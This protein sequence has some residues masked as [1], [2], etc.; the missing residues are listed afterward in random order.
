[1]PD[2]S[3]PIAPQ[4]PLGHHKTSQERAQGR[5][6]S[7]PALFGGI[8]NFQNSMQYVLYIL[9][10]SASY[11]NTSESIAQ[12][13][14]SHWRSCSSCRNGHITSKGMQLVN[15]RIST[16]KTAQDPRRQINAMQ[17][18]HSALSIHQTSRSAQTTHFRFRN[19]FNPICSM[20][21]GCA[22]L[23]TR[24]ANLYVKTRPSKMR[25]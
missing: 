7:H 24:Y 10:T 17:K 16:T 5:P 11:F 19:T 14:I 4:D 1:M 23:S 15:Y 21:S 18:G 12:T 25:G 3:A 13:R 9:L 22:I 6:K 8:L 2:R 20:L